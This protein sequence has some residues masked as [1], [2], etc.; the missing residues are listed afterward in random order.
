MTWVGLL[1]GPQMYV[2]L[3]E[4]L[5]QSLNPPAE[6]N[7]DPGNPGSLAL[8]RLVWFWGGVGVLNNSMDFRSEFKICNTFFFLPIL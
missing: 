2:V 5:P 4:P 3:W 8:S 7:L 1:A 6:C